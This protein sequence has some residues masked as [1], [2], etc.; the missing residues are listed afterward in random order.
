MNAHRNGRGCLRKISVSGTHHFLSNLKWSNT[1]AVTPVAYL[2]FSEPTVFSILNSAS[3]HTT[4]DHNEASATCLPGL[5]MLSQPWM[6]EQAL[7]L[8]HHARRL[9]PNTQGTLSSFSVPS[10]RKNRSGMN[11]SGL[12][13]FISSCDIALLYH[14]NHTRTLASGRSYQ[15]LAVIIAPVRVD[16]PEVLQPSIL[17]TSRNVI[18]LID[19]VFGSGMRNT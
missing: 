8:T 7:I 1:H 11:T 16:R 15:R 4:A 5:Y 14:L 12:G 10:S 13:Y 2:T 9:K 19:I 18:P 3:M 17:L 6:R